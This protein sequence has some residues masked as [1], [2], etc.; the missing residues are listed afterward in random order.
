MPNPQ[1]NKDLHKHCVPAWQFALMSVAFGVMTL[2][3][4]IALWHAA[5]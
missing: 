5:G 4:A 2:N 3:W 1:E